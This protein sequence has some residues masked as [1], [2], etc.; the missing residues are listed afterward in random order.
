MGKIIINDDVSIP[1]SELNFRFDTS[2]G[3]GGQH[4]NRSATRVTLLFDVANSPSLDEASRTKLLENLGHHLDTHGVLH[5][6]VQDTRSQKK[7]REIAKSRFMV[8]MADA[9]TEKAERIE[10]K[11]T[12]HA[13][14][15]QKAEQKKHSQ[16]KKERRT[17]WSKDAC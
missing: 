11:P 4:A 7:N 5:I 13:L 6:S 1:E 2:G 10:T 17:D 15:K 16:R 14:E 9:L 12:S 8:L 3:P